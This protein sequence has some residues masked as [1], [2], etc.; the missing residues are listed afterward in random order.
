MRYVFWFSFVIITLINLASWSA[1]TSSALAQERQGSSKANELIG[2][3]Q[4]VS[5]EKDGQPI[6]DER[7]K[8]STMRIAANAMTTFDKDEKEVYVATYELDTSA[9]PW[10][11]T[12]TAKVA[13]DKGEGAKTS[14]LIEKNG[15]T[16]K[17]VYALPGGKTPTEFKAGDKQ[18]LFV[19][20]KMGN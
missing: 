2:R 6:P 4:L 7:I 13:P 1:A 10:R 11:I 15:D 17:L 9:K 12:M 20:K 14:G 8:G 5:G 16:I 3:Y 18:Q 19:L